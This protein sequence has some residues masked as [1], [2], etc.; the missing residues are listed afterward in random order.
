M[1]IFDLI[2]DKYFSYLIDDLG[3]RVK[4]VS[5]ESN[6]MLISLQKESE[7]IYEEII[8]ELTAFPSFKKEKILFDTESV[9][10]V[11]EKNF[12]ETQKFFSALEELLQYLSVPV[13]S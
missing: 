13:P 2:E 3:F 10:Y 6:C 12:H 5:F 7:D 4:D 11:R 1:V 9:S 8:I